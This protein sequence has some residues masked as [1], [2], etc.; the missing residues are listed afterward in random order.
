MRIL[1]IEDEVDLATALQSALREEGYACDV[2]GDGRAGLFETESRKYDLIVL[3]LMLPEMD[4]L[5]LL[6]HLRAE[7]GTP[8][9]VLTARDTVSDKVA[10]L[11]AGADDYLTKPFELDE[12]LARARALIRRSAEEPRALIVVD[13][14]EIDLAAR[15]VTRGGAAV[16]L[17]PKEFALVEYLA[18]HRGRLVSRTEIMEHLYDHE[19]DT[20]SNVVDVYVSNIRRKLGRDFLRTRRGEGYI[21]DG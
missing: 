12:L 10:V 8:V 21:I 7:Q 19:E 1:V 6:R 2:A 15:A 13:E 4:G 5:T 17:T 20:L 16:G 9:L 3:D 11:D 14:L 18:L